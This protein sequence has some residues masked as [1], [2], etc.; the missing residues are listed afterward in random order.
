MADRRPHAI[1]ADNHRRV[2]PALVPARD[3]VPG[4]AERENR[5]LRDLVAVYRH[6]SGLALQDADV[7]SVARLIAEHL[8]AT[9]AVV[10]PTMDILAAAA[11]HDPSEKAEQ[12]VREHVVHP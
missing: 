3:A 8:A 2:D 1:A 7:A 11:P 5:A 4:A 10:N 9:V 12:Y 6:L